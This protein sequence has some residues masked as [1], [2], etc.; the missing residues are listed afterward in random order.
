MSWGHAGNE[1]FIQEYLPHLGKNPCLHPAPTP[2]VE[3]GRVD[4]ML[5]LYCPHLSSLVEQRSRACRERQA[6]KTR[7]FQPTQH[8]GHKA[9]ESLW[10][11]W[12]S[13]LTP[14]SREGC[15]GFSTVVETWNEEFWNPPQGNGLY[16]KQITREF[17]ECTVKNNEDFGDKQMRRLLA[18]WEQQATKQT[19]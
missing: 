6:K 5:E 4:E 11:K 13:I 8:P 18:P 7:G 12:A 19:I 15:P 10:K 3:L 16:L 1:T 14:S 9:R 2:R 17:S